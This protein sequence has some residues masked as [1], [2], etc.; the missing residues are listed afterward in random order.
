M[1][2]PYVRKC[3][4]ISWRIKIFQIGKKLDKGNAQDFL[5]CQKLLDNSQNPK[6]Y[7]KKSEGWL[8]NYRTEFNR[9][10]TG[11]CIRQVSCLGAV[12]AS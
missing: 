6:S 1:V 2:F 9:K 12:P 3:A 7:I 10:S 4:P 8:L 11:G 5:K